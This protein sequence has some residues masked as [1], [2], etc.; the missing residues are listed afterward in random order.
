MQPYEKLDAWK[1]AHR[2][3][4][5]IHRAVRRWPGEER[6]ALTAQI[7]RAGF[8]IPLNIVEGRARLG[9]KEF[10][11]FLDTAWGSLAEVEY[12]LRLARDLGYLTPDEFERLETL[13][14]Q[15]AKPLYGLLRAMSG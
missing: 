8:S 5:E 4:V 15:V 6:Y 3:A 12:S 1:A 13:R 10:R 7:R 9:R 11:R 14:D 2:L